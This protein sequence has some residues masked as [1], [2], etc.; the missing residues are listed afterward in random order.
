[1]GPLFALWNHETII[2]VLEDSLLLR[3]TMSPIGPVT[4]LFGHFTCIWHFRL[5][6][7]IESIAKG[8]LVVL[9]GDEKGIL[10]YSLVL[11]ACGS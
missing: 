6:V 1:M 4:G 11:P 2:S 10:E 8:Y 5:S 7:S 3:I 9:F